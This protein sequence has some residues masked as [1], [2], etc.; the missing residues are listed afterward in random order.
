MTYDGHSERMRTAYIAACLEDQ[1]MLIEALSSY[2]DMLTDE[3]VA[4]LLSPTPTC[5]TCDAECGGH[6]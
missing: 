2:V 4:D 6:G 5:S 1:S 3:Q